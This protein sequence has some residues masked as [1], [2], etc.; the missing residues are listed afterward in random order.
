MFM[1]CSSIPFLWWKII[2][3][4]QKSFFLWLGFIRPELR[5]SIIFLIIFL[6]I[7][8]LEYRLDYAKL[9]DSKSLEN[10]EDSPN[11]A[12]NT[13][14]GLGA[15]A[16]PP[17]FIESFMMNGL[18]E[19]LFF[20]GFVA[21]ILILRFGIIRGIIIQAFLF[22]IMHNLLFLIGKVSVSF[23]MHIAIFFSTSIGGLLLAFLN[24][25][26]F[27]GSILPSIFLHGL[28][29]FISN[30]GI[31]FKYDNLTLK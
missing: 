29:N 13:Y 20:R 25:I 23:R 31:A 3:Q 19:E 5:Q 10:V 1:I 27:N 21:K 8:I 26:V 7:Y 14:K 9:I 4:G 11:I 15:L 6:I 30:L 16:I 28:G 18:S 2:Y 22:G 24:E 12:A 17:I